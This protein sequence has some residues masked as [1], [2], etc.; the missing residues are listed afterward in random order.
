M[1]LS[2]ETGCRYVI[3]GYVT[4]VQIEL[5]LSNVQKGESDEIVAPELLIS[6]SITVLHLF[7]LRLIRERLYA[8]S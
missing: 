4:G 3:S 2:N 7:K 1:A 8:N 5:V 6:D